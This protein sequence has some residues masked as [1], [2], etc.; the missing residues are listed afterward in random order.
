MKDGVFESGAW[1]V[2]SE[3]VDGGDTVGVPFLFLLSI[4]RRHFS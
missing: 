4:V 2:S 3:G 1:A